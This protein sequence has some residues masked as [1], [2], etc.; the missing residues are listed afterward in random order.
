MP[1]SPDEGEPKSQRQLPRGR[2][3]TSP[4][5]AGAKLTNPHLDESRG[6]AGLEPELLP[7]LLI[8][9]PELSD[10][11]LEA[12]DRLLVEETTTLLPHQR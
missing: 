3:M 8:C 7:Q 6:K 9:D 5:D 4:E 2:R 10:E 11:T 12:R 1:A